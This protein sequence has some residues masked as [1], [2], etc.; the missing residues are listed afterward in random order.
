MLDTKINE[1]ARNQAINTEARKGFDPF[2]YFNNS[3]I[4]FVHISRDALTE[5]ATTAGIQLPQI[6]KDEL[7][8]FGSMADKH[9][10]ILTDNFS[11]PSKLVESSGAFENAGIAE[12]YGDDNE[13]VAL[14]GSS[15]DL[16]TPKSGP[17]FSLTR[18]VAGVREKN[19]AND[20]SVGVLKSIYGNDYTFTHIPIQLATW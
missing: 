19:S 1:V 2:G 20:R 7:I 14:L 3:T 9:S 17:F 4:K 11:I 13:K 18:T 8:L 15:G 16:K 12:L 6:S 5:L 10:E